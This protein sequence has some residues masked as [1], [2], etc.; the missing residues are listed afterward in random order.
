MIDGQ[1]GLLLLPRV[2]RTQNF[3][4]LFCSNFPVPVQESRWVFRARHL[5]FNCQSQPEHSRHKITALREGFLL[6]FLRTIDS[7]GDQE[8]YLCLAA[9]QISFPIQSLLYRGKWGLF[10]WFHFKSKHKVQRPGHLLNIYCFCSP[11]LA[12]SHLP[13]LC[14]FFLGLE[15]SFPSSQTQVQS[16]PGHPLGSRKTQGRLYLFTSLNFQ[17]CKIWRKYLP[18]VV[19]LRTWWGNQRHTGATGR[20]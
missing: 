9:S 7:L 10:R 12:I 14:R 6:P 18:W 17:S 1:D 5:C 8:P 3:L 15:F 2:F 19:D 16:L 11:W 4:V 20:G 13:V